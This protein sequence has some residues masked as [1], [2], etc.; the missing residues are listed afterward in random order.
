MPAPPLMI[1][2][3]QRFGSSFAIILPKAAREALT[4]LPGDLVAIRVVGRRL[5]VGK[6]VPEQVMPVSDEEASAALQT[7]SRSR[8]A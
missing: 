7:D 4:I 1:S 5:V 8:G 2:K 6:L 3:V